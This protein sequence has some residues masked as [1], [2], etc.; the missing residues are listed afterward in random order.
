M[1]DKNP[2]YVGSCGR[3]YELRCAGFNF[4][5]GACYLFRVTL[6]KRQAAQSSTFVFPSVQD[7]YGDYIPRDK[8]CIDPTASIVVKIV[9]ACVRAQSYHFLI[10]TAESTHRWSSLHLAGG[11]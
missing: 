7:A 10:F 8:A 6:R 4:S 9:D 3:C 2:D 11:S 1:S 5:V